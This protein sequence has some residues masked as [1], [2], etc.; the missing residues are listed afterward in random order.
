MPTSDV[1]FSFAADGFAEK[2]LSVVLVRNGQLLTALG[3][4]GS[5]HTTAI[6]SCHALTEAMLVHAATVVGLKCSFHC[7]S[8]LFLLLLLSIWA[9]KLSII[10]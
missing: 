9:A 2:L 5:Q 1:T 6:L 7:P 4:A 8:V 10:F 3:A